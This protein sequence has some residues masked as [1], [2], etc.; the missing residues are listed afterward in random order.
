MTTNQN[1]L[2]ISAAADD[3]KQDKGEY[4]YRG[5][6]GRSFERRLTSQTMLL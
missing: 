3:N 4:L 5:I 2:I 1:V 6:A